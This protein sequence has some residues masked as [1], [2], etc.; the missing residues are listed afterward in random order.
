MFIYEVVQS[1]EWPENIKDHVVWNKCTYMKSTRSKNIR[2]LD[3]SSEWD[4]WQKESLNGESPTESGSRIKIDVP[5]WAVSVLTINY[6]Y[7]H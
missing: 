2:Q 1:L 5:D 7:K 4:Q 3:I 6:N